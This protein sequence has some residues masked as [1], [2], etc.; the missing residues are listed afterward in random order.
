MSNLLPYQSIKNDGWNSFDKN[1]PD[2]RQYGVTYTPNASLRFTVTGKHPPESYD[3]KIGFNGNI[4]KVCPIMPYIDYSSNSALALQEQ[5]IIKRKVSND[6]YETNIM[7]DR[8]SENK[9]LVERHLM[10]NQ[11]LT[12]KA[13][14]AIRAAQRTRIVLKQA[15]LVTKTESSL[16]RRTNHHYL[17]VKKSPDMIELEQDAEKLANSM[18]NDNTYRYDSSAG[19]LSFTVSELIRNRRTI[20]TILGPIV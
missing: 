8:Q 5:I 11:Q 10:M 12:P 13:A 15:Q 6:Y 19:W 4:R 17:G 7:A 1:I 14:Q 3:S 20:S 2:L 9:S 16:I 18:I